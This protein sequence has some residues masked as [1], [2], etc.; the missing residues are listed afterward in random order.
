[1][2]KLWCI[3]PNWFSPACFRCDCEKAHVSPAVRHRDGGL[4]GRMMPHPKVSV[5]QTDTFFLLT[6]CPVSG[7]LSL[8]M[9]ITLMDATADRD[10]IR[11]VH[12][13]CCTYY[14]KWTDAD[15][16]TFFE[17]GG[18]MKMYSRT[19]DVS[20][21]AIGMVAY[22]PPQTYAHR[23][24]ELCVRIFMFGIAPNSRL[25]GNGTQFFYRL[26]QEWFLA[27]ATYLWSYEHNKHTAGIAFWSSLGFTMSSM[28]H[29]LGSDF[30]YWEKSLLCQQKLSPFP[31][32]TM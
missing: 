21:D 5:S 25:Q 22:Y 15:V 26:A 7:I 8:T 12:D 13:T 29:E 32:L 19:P 3:S 10:I 6:F 24:E 4:P 16:D 23:G 14:R 28:Q 17:N 1:M 2:L 11:Q 9:Q 18:E 30:S 20:N 27:G 31:S